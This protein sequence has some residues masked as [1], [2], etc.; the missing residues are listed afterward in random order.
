DERT[1]DEQWATFLAL[2]RAERF[3]LAEAPLIRCALVRWGSDQHRFVLTNHHILMDG[4]SM[5]ILVREL[6]TLYAQDGD[7]GGADAALPRPTPY[8][9]YLAWLAA[10]DREAAI[11]A[12][13][14]AL[15]GLEGPT[16]LSPPDP[17]RQPV[18]PELLSLSLS[19]DLTRALSEQAR[20]QGVTLNTM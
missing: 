5:P 16:R 17:A 2:D 1:R 4:W 9:D 10:Q 15:A 19:E 18:A 11:A 6:L 8:R 20:R 7:H 12:W 3:D 13:R 14:E